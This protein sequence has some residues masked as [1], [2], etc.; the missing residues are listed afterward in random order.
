ME[1]SQVEKCI[2]EVLEAKFGCCFESVDAGRKYAFEGEKY[3]FIFPHSIAEYATE[4][5]LKTTANRWLERDI[6]LI[7]KNSCVEYSSQ[8]S[9]RF[10]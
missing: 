9:I 10:C 4:S 5:K 7:E 2:Q 1:V 8:G 6:K 3:K